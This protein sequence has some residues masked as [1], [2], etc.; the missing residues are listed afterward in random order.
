MGQLRNKCVLEV[1]SSANWT[2]FVQNSSN[3]FYVNGE[4]EL[5]GNASGA[6][7]TL[8]ANTRVKCI[9]SLFIQIAIFLLALKYVLAKLNMTLQTY[10]AVLPPCFDCCCAKNPNHLYSGPVPMGL[11]AFIVLEKILTM[12][13]QA[14]TTC[15]GPCL[16]PSS[17]SHWTTGRTSITW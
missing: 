4:P 3:W 16:Q 2:Y 7:Y 14:L 5:C 11:C 12:G 8:Y 10:F 1:P 17:W 6:R 13:S 9:I 15:S